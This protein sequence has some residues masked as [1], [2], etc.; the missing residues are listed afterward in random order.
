MRFINCPN[1]L[2]HSDDEHLNNESTIG[3]SPLNHRKRRSRLH[4]LTKALFSPARASFSANKS[5]GSLCC[6]SQNTNNNSNNNN[7]H[8][9]QPGWSTGHT[10][11]RLERKHKVKKRDLMKQHQRRTEI[12]GNLLQFSC[13]F[14]CLLIC[15][16]PSHRKLN[17]NNIPTSTRTLL[18]DCEINRKK[19]IEKISNENKRENCSILLCCVR[20]QLFP[21]NN[22][23]VVLYY[24][25][26]FLISGFIRIVLYTENEREKHVP[27]KENKKNKFLQNKWEKKVRFPF[28]SSLF[29]DRMK[30]WNKLKANNSNRMLSIKYESLDYCFALF[31]LFQ[32]FINWFTY[33]Y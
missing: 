5:K 14:F 7:N 27:K 15:T 18:F 11:Y 9:E 12:T 10:K 22:A 16:C 20:L 6:P 26:R 4:S 2:S 3:C 24:Q 25:F 30:S 29:M 28:S 8:L 13:F 23:H 33:L 21:S 32:L 19:L 1:C 17:E 31:S